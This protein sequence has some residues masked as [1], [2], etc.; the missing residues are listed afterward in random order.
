MLM[1]RLISKNQLPSR[2]AAYAATH[3]GAIYRSAKFADYGLTRAVPARMLA[4]EM[5]TQEL[6]VWSCPDSHSQPES[7]L[8]NKNNYLAEKEKNVVFYQTTLGDLKLFTAHWL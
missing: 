5:I 2:C 6:N 8:G 3:A 4:T 7:S 1:C